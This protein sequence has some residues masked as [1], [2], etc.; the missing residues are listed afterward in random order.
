MG[1][2]YYELLDGR[3][4]GYAV[5]AECD[6][7][8]CRVRIGRGLGNLCG[9]N[10]L[11]HKDDDE[12]GCANYFCEPHKHDHDCPSP[13]CGLFPADGGMSCELSEGHE[14]PHRS[15]D[16]EFIKTESPLLRIAPEVSGQ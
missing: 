4:A 14:L 16:G 15:E 13:E 6:H 9:R 7:P 11:G 12:P 10:P 2:S 3:Q 5:T 1:Y 8:S